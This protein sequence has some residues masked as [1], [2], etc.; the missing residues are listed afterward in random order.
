VALEDPILR[1]WPQPAVEVALEG[2]YLREGLQHK[3]RDRAGLPFVYTNFIA[4]LDG[5]IALPHPE[6]PA[7]A[8]PGELANPRDWRLFQEL[9][10]QADAIVTSG[11]YM[12]ERAV[13]GAQDV[14]AVYQ[15]AAFADLRDWRLAA[16]LA[17]EPAV[18]IM[19]LTLDF[20]LPSFL[21]GANRPV[22]VFTGAEASAQRIAGLA[23]AG[24]E[25]VQEEGPGPVRGGSVVHGL[26]ARGYRSIYSVTGPEVM[27]T[28][29]A[30]D[31]LDRLYITYAHRL[32]GGEQYASLVEGFRLVRPVDMQLATMYYDAHAPDGAGQCFA[33]FDRRYI[34]A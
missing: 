29:L 9:A 15:D 5:R 28:L 31:V 10:A 33:R 30:A 2:L 4:S 11:R 34:Q 24:V 19:S 20:P 13:G 22:I 14:L 3:H 23:G 32:L 27:H 25:V 26:A 12:R 17:A 7:M 6:K 18:V 16:G 8:V 21:R 1:L